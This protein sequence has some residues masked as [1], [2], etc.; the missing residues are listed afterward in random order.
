[1]FRHRLLGKYDVQYFQ[2]GDCGFLQT[3][4]PYWLDEAYS[5]AITTA[6]TGILQRNHYLSNVGALILWRLFSGRGKF[7]DAAGGYGIYTRLMRDFGFD[8]YWC[9][10]HAQNLVARGFEGEPTAGPY[11][12]VSAFEVLEHLVDPLDF[13]SSLLRQT[14]AKAFIATTELFSGAVPAPESWWYYAFPTGQHISFYRRS[15]LDVI[16]R[17]LGLKLYSNRNFHLWTNEPMS[18]FEFNLFTHGRVAALL[19]WMP[20][21]ALES[22]MWPDHDRLMKPE[23]NKRA[24]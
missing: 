4:T 1:M 14:Q 18:R 22:K 21:L 10:P 16:S 9:D 5:S 11:V 3:E 20:R 2:C 17:K 13:I 23:Q 24:G 19:S 7:L 6:D 12:A 8:Y 15:T